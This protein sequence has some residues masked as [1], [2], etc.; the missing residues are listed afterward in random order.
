MNVRSVF[1]QLDKTISEW[2][3]AHGVLLLRW[4]IGLVF[5]WF[6]ALKLVP[7]LSPADQLATETTVA[8]TFGLLS[9]D[10]ARLGLSL[11]EMTIGAGLLT[12]RFLRLTLL[13]LFGQMAGTFTP[14]ILFPDLIWT[15]F[16]FGLTLEGQ[17]IVK[18]G[19]LIS[20]GFVI[21]ATVRGGRIVVESDRR[22]E[23][24]S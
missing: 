24:R 10:V 11:L 5:L 21:G 1:D 20:A 7:G 22:A 23:D 3:A 15:S 17:Y 6:G 4:S 9:E 13:L 2:M 12:G 19:V 16:P 14:M 18:N 8:L